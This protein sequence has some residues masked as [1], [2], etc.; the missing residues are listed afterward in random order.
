MYK[1]QKLH[2]I[3]YIS[4]IIEAIKQ[5]FVLVIIFL[6]FNLKDFDFKNYT[7]YIYPG[8]VAI[9]FIV[10]F[11]IH[12]LK[13]YKTRYWIE[14]DHFIL[15]SG[16]FTKQRKEL[17]IRRI[18]SVDTTQGLVNQLVGGVVLQIKTPS[19]G[20]ELDTVSKK[21][22]QLIQQAIKQQQL[23]LQDNVVNDEV[24]Q[25]DNDN[26]VETTSN[27][28]DQLYKL[29]F[30]NLLLMAMTSGAIGI[31]FAAIMPILGGFSDIIP[32][33][34]ITNKVEH[35]AQAVSIIVI[36][37]VFTILILSYIIGTIITIVRYFN[38]TLTQENNQLN[39]SYGLF[40]IQNITV[41][42]DRVQAVIE[43]QSF[44]R[45]IF[46]Y[47][48]IHF[49]ITS[50]MDRNL[51]DETIDGKVMVL[52]FIKRRDAFNIIKGLV[53]YFEFNESEKGMPLRSLHRYFI[54]EFFVLLIIGIV[55]TYFWS[56]WSVVIVSVVLLF[57]ISNAI[58]NVKYAGYKVN[59]EEIVVHNVSIIGVKNNYFKRDKILGMEN[60]QTPFLKR[61][62]LTTF[63]YI[64]AKASGMQ[65]IGLKYEDSSTVQSL[66]KWYLRGV[67]HE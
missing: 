51:D 1:P 61:S 42:T 58:L 63:R 31:A 24:L 19:D 14:K 20:I 12:S 4:G 64:I 6:V 59:N 2:P 10:S 28:T 56:A 8:I 15:T 53:P 17:N 37:I 27:S 22:S 54:K 36:I 40:K 50:D 47:T 48:A 41:P 9:I 38:Y 5:N 11:I 66:K 18:Q 16:V 46:G 44:L 23:S 25:S 55:G 32:W 35:I 43:N 39:I 62:N 34:A 3:S 13:V 29:S 49:V 45:K 65:K 52:P 67:W 30:K 21:Q 26:N 33:N 57:F 60:T 7:S